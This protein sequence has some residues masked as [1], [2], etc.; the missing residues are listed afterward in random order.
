MLKNLEFSDINFSFAI[1]LFKE[2]IRQKYL[3]ISNKSISF[4]NK[5]LTKK[6]FPEASAP[7]IIS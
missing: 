4:A 3:E 5:E 7:L 2:I 6:E 1:S